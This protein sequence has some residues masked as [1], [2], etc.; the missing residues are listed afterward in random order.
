MSTILFLLLLACGNGGGAGIRPPDIPMAGG[1]GSAD[2]DSDSI[3]T[4][5]EHAQA[6]LRARTGDDTLT[7]TAITSARQQ[8]VAGMNYELVVHLTG[9]AGEKRGVKVLV[10]RSLQDEW[11]LSSV[12]GL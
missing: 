4:A 7:I 8:V 9:A 12:E 10:F 11:S 5:G 3:R 6:L 2:P 1:F